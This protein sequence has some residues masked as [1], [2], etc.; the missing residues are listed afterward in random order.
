MNKTRIFDHVHIVRKLDETDYDSD[1][2][3]DAS[4]V[5]DW[6]YSNG[7]KWTVDGSGRELPPRNRV[8]FVAIGGDG[9]MLYTMKK[10]LEYQ[11]S[12]VVG[13]NQG[14]L[15]FLVEDLAG[16]QIEKFLDDVSECKTTFD[17]RMVLTTSIHGERHVAVNEFLFST[18]T[19]NAPFTY[20]V[21]INDQIV[22]E[23]F[24]SGVMVA[25]ST[26]STAMS[27]SAGGVIV[28]PSTNIM[29][30]VPLV[31]HSLSA[32]PIITT[33]RDKISIETTANDR[34]SDFELRADGRRVWD[35]LPSNNKTYRIDFH[36]YDQKVFIHRPKEW[37]F[38]D[39]LTE[40]LKW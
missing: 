21:L 17:E 25:T 32:R 31:S 18:G 22:A 7:L 37:N 29:Q 3:R 14:S 10:S 36:K 34:N 39:V 15:G 23:Q 11:W 30:I 16:H 35:N 5:A 6:A 26:G 13:I 40:K 9:T 33:G 2:N 20:K 27:L 8:L 4:I 19:H 1:V 38:F 28:S 24:G 12:S